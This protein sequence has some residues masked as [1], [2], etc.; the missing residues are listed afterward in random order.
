MF[1]LK[2]FDMEIFDLQARRRRI[3]ERLTCFFPATR[4]KEHKEIE[5]LANCSNII[6]LHVSRLCSCL[7]LK[8]VNLLQNEHNW[9][10][11]FKKTKIPADKHICC[12]SFYLRKKQARNLRR[13]ALK[14]GKTSTRKTENLA[15]L[16][17]SPTRKKH[18]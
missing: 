15:H 2:I 8:S 11:I 7:G 5:N 1:G 3:E 12:V 17:L 9:I 13:C 14:A 16:T 10:H 4:H 6:V 18:I